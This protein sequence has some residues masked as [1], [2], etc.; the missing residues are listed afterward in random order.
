MVPHSQSIF[1]QQAVIFSLMVLMLAIY[2]CQLVTGFHLDHR[3]M[4]VP[5]E[6]TEAWSQ[7]RAGQVGA[8]ELW[9]FVTLLTS[10]F[11]HGGFDHLAGNML[12]YWVFGGLLYELLGW[13][14]L[15]LLI[16]MTAI[17]GSATHS[18]MNAESMTPMLGASGVVSGF[19]GAYLGL[20][21]RWH[22]PDPHIWPISGPVPPVRLG[23]LAVILIG[24]DYY[25]IFKNFNCGVA[26]GA[27]I[28]G[29]TMG[30]FLTGF[31]ARRPAQAE[32]RR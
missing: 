27:H 32:P 6:V 23:A 24:H 30:L 8:T 17:G 9:T 13:R 25:F 16:V 7:L 31:I 20:C 21:T 2:V 3:V 10:A 12:Y 1:R 14:W 18:A 4:T 26:Y 19:A 28:G 22:L 11:L 15:L 29:F 5:A